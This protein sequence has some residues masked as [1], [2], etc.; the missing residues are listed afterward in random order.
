MEK[1]KL[2]AGKIILRIFLSI[3]SVILVI[4]LCGAGFIL[5]GKNK[6]IHAPLNGIS[7][8]SVADGTYEGSYS[9]FRWSNTVSVKVQDHKIVGIEQIK[10]QVVASQDTI[11]KLIASVETAQSTEIDVVSGA[12]A[13]TRAFL[14]AVEDALNP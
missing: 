13:D 12:T 11:D 6:T 9:G 2:T 3:I 8:S 14:S 7:L 10:P 1:K 4:C 5:L